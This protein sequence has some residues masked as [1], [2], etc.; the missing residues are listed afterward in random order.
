MTETIKKILMS[1]YNKVHI[2]Y[3]N[4]IIIIII[5]LGF[6]GLPWIER[7]EIAMLSLSYSVI[8]ACFHPSGAPHGQSNDGIQSL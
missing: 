8:V 6:S 1:I 5:K 7:I 4:Y 2:L 3:V